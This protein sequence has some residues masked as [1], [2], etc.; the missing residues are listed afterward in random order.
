MAS[1][2]KHR[3]RSAILAL[4]LALMVAG[5]IAWQGS[6][7]ASVGGETIAASWSTKPAVRNTP[8]AS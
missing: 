8:P 1:N 5:G 2:W 4:T 6:S 3:V 7:I